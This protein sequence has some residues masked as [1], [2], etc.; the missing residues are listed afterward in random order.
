[1]PPPIVAPIT[2]P[3]PNLTVCFSLTPEGPVRRCL[4]ADSNG[5]LEFDVHNAYLG[6]SRTYYLL[7]SIA[8]PALLEILPYPHLANGSLLPPMASPYLTPS[9][10]GSL[11]NGTDTAY[12]A[13][14]MSAG[15]NGS[16]DFI[17]LPPPTVTDDAII[18]DTV[19]GWVIAIIVILIL[20]VLLAGAYVF[21][22]FV[23]LGMMKSNL[24]ITDGDD[25]PMSDTVSTKVWT[26]RTSY[27][28]M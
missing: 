24:A 25:V 20:V 28:R 23:Y 21:Y 3:I 18:G 10:A 4:K 2:P 15:F 8:D 27:H 12:L 5:T 11:L 6:L 16:L 9:I 7:V 1:M 22:R 17:N 26:S 14:S 19:E 13:W